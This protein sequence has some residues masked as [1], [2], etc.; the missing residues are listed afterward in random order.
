MTVVV[1]TPKCIRSAYN[2]YIGVGN[3]VPTMIA[4]KAY[5]S[6]DEVSTDSWARFPEHCGCSAAKAGCLIPLTL[7][8]R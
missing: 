5:A 4:A 3:V 6:K 1:S 2:A 7:S 8:A